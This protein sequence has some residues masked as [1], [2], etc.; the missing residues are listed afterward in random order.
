[1]LPVITCVLSLVA[2]VMIGYYAFVVPATIARFLAEQGSVPPE[3]ATRA[4]LSRFFT[5]YGLILLPLPLV[6]I[7]LSAWWWVR[8]GREGA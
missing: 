3:Y 4:A 1:M 2:L 7:G 8:S 6:G 5:S